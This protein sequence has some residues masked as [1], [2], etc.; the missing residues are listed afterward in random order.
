MKASRSAAQAK[1]QKKNEN[2]D[3]FARLADLVR[4][5]QWRAAHPGYRHRRTKVGR[6]QIRG[7]LAE[8]VQE[9]ASQDE[10]DALFSL[11][12]GLLSH[13]SGAASQD[14]IATEIR[15]LSLIGHGVLLQSAGVRDLSQQ[16][17]TQVR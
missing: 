10:I 5:Q 16:S 6:Y 1:W 8:V 3:H 7:P 12:I 14:E 2:R 9:L 4:M 17:V 13:L 11:V 15:R